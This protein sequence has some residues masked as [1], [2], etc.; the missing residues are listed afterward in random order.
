MPPI[1]YRDGGRLKRLGDEAAQAF[2]STGA[3]LT[4][5]IRK[6]A[7]EHVLTAPEVQRVCEAANHAV[8]A[9]RRPDGGVV[10]FEMARVEKIAGAAPR[11]PM[12]AVEKTAREKTASVGGTRPEPV[13]DE[14]FRK[15]PRPV[16][17]TRSGPSP[18][19]AGLLGAGVGGIGGAMVGYGTGAEKALSKTTRTLQGLRGA[20]LG[21]LIGGSIGAGA[22]VLTHA[23]E[24][25]ASARHTDDE[26]STLCR[27]IAQN[28]RRQSEIAEKIAEEARDRLAENDFALSN[29]VVA[30]REDLISLYRNEGMKLAEVMEAFA[31]YPKL[32]SEPGAL[33]GVANLVK[34]VGRE[35]Y[36]PVTFTDRTME[37]LTSKT[38]REKVAEAVDADL[39]AGGLHMS[40]MPVHIING[41]HQVWRDLDTLVDQYHARGSVVQ[42]VK[43]AD[44]CVHFTRSR[45]RVRFD[46]AVHQAGRPV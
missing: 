13:E 37:I 14:P 6:L 8:H 4:S 20:G 39:I 3:D 9:H 17:S 19:A 5:S 44:D 22:A 2:L 26:D 1:T 38:A 23:A 40:G 25:D 28:A 15:T 24:K 31:E 21:M 30:L 7:T 34:R 16:H 42:G 35:L 36:D 27:A 43:G 10:E 45:A 41:E 32:A 18:L 33:L 11:R 46:A 12:V 29:S